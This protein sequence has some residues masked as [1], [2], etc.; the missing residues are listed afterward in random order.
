MTTER[1][2]IGGAQHAA[3]LARMGR[4]KTIRPRLNDV[5]FARKLVSVAVA[6]LLL[7]V[8]LFDALALVLG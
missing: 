4:G 5:E 3:P 6:P 1:R 8:A 7:I 2:Q